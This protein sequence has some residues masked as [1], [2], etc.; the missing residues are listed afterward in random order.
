M[1][2]KL[3]AFIVGATLALSL[4]A[5]VL[6][7]APPRDPAQQNPDI[8]EIAGYPSP[9]LQKLNPLTQKLKNG[10]REVRYR[11]IVMAGCSDGNMRS[12]LLRALQSTT[13][14]TG[15]KFYEDSTNYDLTIRANCGVNFTNICGSG[16]AVACLGRG[17]PYVN[18]IDLNTVMATFYDLSQIS[19]WEHE[20]IGHA[21]GTWDEQYQFNGLFS[22]TPNLVDFMNTGVNSRYD[23]P[24]LSVERW[25]RTMW[26]PLTVIPPCTSD[27]CW[28]GTY[29]T[30]K[31]GWKLN[32]ATDQWFDP[33][34]KLYFNAREFWG[35]R[36]TAISLPSGGGMC[37]NSGTYIYDQRLGDPWLYV[38]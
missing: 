7:D 27:P 29:W 21:M 13:T 9:E 31:S 12:T 37:Y 6:A 18:D 17:W 35:G 28:D 16:G 24:Q 10:S 30:W 38:P 14:Q 11:Y 36:C 33:T 1:L 19:I 25:W 26:M 22:P 15:V 20:F 3:L 23:W 5:P 4:V 2:R 34:G 8:Y 32:P